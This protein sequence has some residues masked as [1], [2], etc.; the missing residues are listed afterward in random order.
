MQFNYRPGRYTYT[1]FVL[2]VLLPAIFLLPL[3]LTYFSRGMAEEPAHLVIV[4]IMYLS[5]AAVAVILFGMVVSVV[6]AVK[7]RRAGKEITVTVD[8]TGAVEKWDGGETSFAWG[9]VASVS[10]RFGRLTVKSGGA[11]WRI[12]RSD[13]GRRVFNELVSTVRGHTAV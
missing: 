2:R 3:A 11:V 1:N 8:E 10:S 5:F 4:Y 12:Y 6:N 9:D 13:V 7:Y